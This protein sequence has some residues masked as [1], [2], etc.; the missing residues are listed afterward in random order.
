MSISPVLDLH[1]AG[2]T[3]GFLSGCV[4]VFL[5]KGSRRHA[6]AGNVFVVSMLT[7]A[8]TGMLMAV[9]KS[10]P[11]NIL[12]GALT[13]Y[14]VLTSWLTARHRAG[15]TSM[16][17]WLALF[18]GLAVAAAE[19]TLAVEAAQSP[20]G[21]KYGYPPAAFAVFGSIALLAVV[22][23]VR[24]L[25]R[26]GIAGTQR[27]ARHLWRMNFAWFI[28]SASIFL[29]R[30]HL[31]PVFFRKSGL[32]IFLTVLPLIMLIF[33]FARVRFSRAFKRQVPI[34]TGE[35]RV[36]AGKQLPAR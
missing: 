13:F 2:G 14:L 36:A 10:Q 8:S 34:R 5:R 25:V 35:N 31:F 1:I 33:W 12:G 26:R 6:V 9:M 3:V 21:H 32:L 27:L 16:L 17:D 30:P 24:M 29:A 28:A 7:L 4:A 18:V 11:P 19:Y 23:D 20:T 22:G 15:E